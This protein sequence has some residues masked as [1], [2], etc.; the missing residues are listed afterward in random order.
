LKQYK[1]VAVGGTFDQFHIGHEHLIKTALSLGEQVLIGLT[2]DTLL[3][4]YQKQHK[5]QSYPQRKQAIARFLEDHCAI[6]TGRIVSLHDVFG[7]SIR[8]PEIDAL[9]VSTESQQRAHLVNQIRFK[10][11]FESLQLIVIDLVLAQDG[12]P[13]SASRIRN[14]EIDRFGNILSSTKTA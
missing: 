13:I 1:K 10:K 14:N 8:D 5:T 4:T 9:V 3:Q 2:T 7:S 6:L 12:K 11:G